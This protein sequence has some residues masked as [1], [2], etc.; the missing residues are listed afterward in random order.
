MET[1]LAKIKGILRYQLDKNV[2]A[3]SRAS[4]LK[5]DL[6]MDSID[7]VEIV[8]ALEGEYGLQISDEDAE[9][10]NTVGDIKLYV[11]AR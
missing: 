1:V 3:I 4:K 2:E 5:D 6:G 9:K 7:L 11:E 10:W 8:M